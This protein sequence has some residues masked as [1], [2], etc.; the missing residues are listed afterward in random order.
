[1][2][3]HSATPARTQRFRRCS[4][5]A[6]GCSDDPVE[7]IANRVGL[8]VAKS[9]RE[10]LARGLRSLMERHGV[11]DAGQFLRRL[12]SDAGLVDEVIATMTV[13]ET[14]F[15]RDPAQFDL[16]RDEVLPSM[17]ADRQASSPIRIWSAGCATG[18]EA[19][20]LAVLVDEM[21]LAG[22]AQ[23]IATDV[24]RNALEVA[25]QGRYGRRSLRGAAAGRM[26]PYLMPRDGQ[27]ILMGKYRRQV[28]FDQ[29]CLG[30]DEL[31]CHSKG[32]ANLDIIMCRNLLIYLR[33]EVVRR[34]ARQIY[35]CLKVGGWLLLGPS[36]PPLWDHA[37]FA[38][39][40]TNAGILYR[41]NPAVRSRAAGPHVAVEHPASAP[42]A[43]RDPQENASALITSERLKRAKRTR[44]EDHLARPI[45]KYLASGS[46]KAAA[47]L[48]I[49]A[50]RIHPQSIRL[51]Y[52]LALALM[53]QSHLDEA[54]AALRRLSY[55]DGSLAA[56]HY[57][58]GVCL[59]D[60]DPCTAGQAFSIAY[61][62]CARRSP[63]ESVEL[64]DDYNAG[65]LALQIGREIAEMTYV[66]RG[67]Y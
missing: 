37:P 11:K 63:D 61:E 15:F 62:L 40:I 28:R 19:Y 31:P 20:S 1:M 27:W 5:Q 44:L 38:T 14:Y 49:E 34:I 43:G 2:Q 48:A 60:S 67:S 64:M 3:S 52:L 18:E 53:S 46:T 33:P 22:R 65:R 42:S 56:A 30:R 21:G 17:K 6:I 10:V 23:I 13:D 51:H 50:T 12:D 55:L 7:V 32:L 54:V 57:L 25:R 4:T 29:L 16:I 45:Q 24:S 41:R 58:L 39:L 59:R 8:N 35:S 36:D 9:R 66:S 47:A 26:K